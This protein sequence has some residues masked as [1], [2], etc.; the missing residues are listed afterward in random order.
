MHRRSTLPDHLRFA[1]TVYRTASSRYTLASAVAKGY[2][3]YCPVAHALDLVGERWSLL[4]VRELLHGPL[5]YSDLH[6]RL[7]GC[8]TN[9]LAARLKR[10]ERCG[11]IRKHRLPPPAASTVYEL[12]PYGARLRR[13]VHEIARWGVRSL[14]PPPPGVQLEPGWLVH[15]LE[16]ITEPVP[17]WPDVSVEFRV[18]EEV[19]SIVAGS[20]CTGGAGAPDAVVVTDAIGFYNLFVE[21]DLDGVGID[22]DDGAV[23]QVVETAAL[24][25]SDPVTV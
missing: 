3:Q 1:S 8:G 5:R 4:V 25:A 10:L 11:V 14:G 20:P 18:D 15:A 22:G 7:P 24:A 23:R 12:T 21:G 9:I 17:A 13:V 19:A 2:H 16:A 6:E